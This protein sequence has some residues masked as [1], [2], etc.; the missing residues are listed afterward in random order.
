[1]DKIMKF[2][3]DWKVLFSLVL[4]MAI[5]LWIAP[6]AF[7]KV[8]TYQT[9]KDHGLSN[10]G[11]VDSNTAKDI[12]SVL[13]AQVNRL[14]LPGL[15]AS[16]QTAEGLTW[17]GASGTID[18]ERHFPLSREH[19]IRVGSVTK[20]FTAVIILQL[21]EEGKLSLDDSLARWFPDFPNAD[22]ITIREMLNH[23][24]GIYDIL[25]NPAV[26]VSLLFPHKKWQTLELVEIAAQEKPGAQG[27]YS[28]SNTNYILLGLIA[29]RIT[30]Q[31]AVVFYR[32]RILEPLGLHSTFFVPYETIPQTLI[33]GYDRDLLPL[34]GLFKLKP[35]GVSAATAAYT[36]GAMIS[37]A[38]DLRIFYD[39]LFSGK[40][41]PPILIDEMAIFLPAADTGTPQLTGYG[42]GLFRL[43][44]EGEEV[45]ASLGEFIGSMS[46][47]AYSPGKKDIVAI[48]GNLSI[49]DFVSVW[50]NL[51]DISRANLN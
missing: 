51:T 33:S 18:P 38:D 40:L 43:E 46:M 29:E 14:G 24:S 39:G 31:E 44:I 34:P 19:T 3:L 25:R 20:T 22:E 2:L 41:I 30:R 45:W 4:I 47:I 6:T 21:V 32:Q 5:M 17:S 23:R 8:R 49:Y 26:L 16:I 36:S 48:I 27:V 35:D 28:Y 10:W 9:P 12:Q 11:T 50:K 42:L 15:Q 37:T 13:D 1:M 7:R